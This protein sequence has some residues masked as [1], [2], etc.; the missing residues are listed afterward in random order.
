MLVSS[1]IN[2][3]KY[4]AESTR[5]LLNAIPDSALNF[6]VTNHELSWTTAQLASHIVNIYSWY[7]STL[8]KPSLDMAAFGHIPYDIDNMKSILTR[9]EE[10]VAKA[11]SA[12][13]RMTEETLAEN[14]TMTVGERVIIPPTPRVAVM[15]SFLMN[16]L[17][18]HRGEMIVYLRS[19]GNTVPGLYGPTREDMAARQGK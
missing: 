19:S 1:L 11:S 14:W 9:F 18:H 2:E 3:F 6:K 7:E 8:L 5:K 12:I 4:E 16:H 15:R 10:N 17:Y 13:E